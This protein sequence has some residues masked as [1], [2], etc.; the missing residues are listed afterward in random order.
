M[1]NESRNQIEQTNI[2]NEFKIMVQSPIGQPQKTLNEEIG[3]KDSLTNLEGHNQ[4]FGT[5]FQED[6]N[7]LQPSL[8]DIKMSQSPHP[9][10]VGINQSKEHSKMQSQDH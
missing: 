1:K 6:Q 4:R 9:A 10:M 3:L 7:H 5:V 8:K 2:E